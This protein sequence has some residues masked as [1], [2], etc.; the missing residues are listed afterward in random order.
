MQSPLSSIKNIYRREMFKPTWLSVFVNPIYFMRKEIYFNLVKFAPYMK[1]RMLD[2]GCGTKAYKGIFNVTEHIGVDLEV[3]EGHNNS[4]AEIDFFYDGKTLPFTD[5]SFD[6]VFSSEVFEHVFN[7]EEIVKE[8]NRVLRKDG[9]LL[10]T[11]P[12][13]WQEHEQP[14]DFARY[15]TFGIKHLLESNGF[16]IIHQ[17]KGPNF[18]RSLM[19]LHA[20]YVY[21]N[22]L[23]K[24]NTLRML[25]SL[26]LIAPINITGLIGGAF[27]P[28]GGE[29]FCNQCI[30]AQKVSD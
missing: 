7:L 2:F 18:F 28:N 24:S 29:M 17:V 5:K 1:G 19:Q 3:N 27:L 10:M 23:P 13:L 30:V 4:N 16:K 20:A 6:S 12:F 26:F 21:Y 8:L 22:L 15:T 25:L 14:N 11:I 9:H